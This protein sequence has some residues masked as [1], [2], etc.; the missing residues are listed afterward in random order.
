MNI[1]F[2]EDDLIQ[3]ELIKNYLI[4]A[5]YFC[6]SFQ[7]GKKLL[8]TLA[9]PHD[10][11]LVILDW[12]VPDVSGLDVLHWIR[13]NQGYALP[14][15]FLTSR[16]DETDL[17]TGLQSGADDYICKPIRKGELIARVQA[18]LRRLNPI[19]Q[20]NEPFS[21]GVYDIDPI[22]NTI[23][24]KNKEI[25]LAPKEFEL[26][27][28]F[29]RNPGRLFSRDVLSAAVWNREIL[30]TSRTLDTHLSN[31]R[32]KLALKPENGV[33]LNASYALGYRLDSLLDENNTSKH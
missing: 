1:A 10:F 22:N 13:S 12:E 15:L 2:L 29:F 33:R 3:A 7:S 11:D 30:A 27:L 25:T 8:A 19:T 16:T 32:R 24:L 6:S 20:S 23:S 14:V 21:F 17:I 5:D 26:A 31:I 9:K 28:L 18:L 4:S